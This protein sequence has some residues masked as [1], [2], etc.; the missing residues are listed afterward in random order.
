M[1]YLLI[2]LIIAYSIPGQAQ[3]RLIEGKIFAFNNYPLENIQ[4]TTK[5]S[6]ES[7][8]TDENGQFAIEVKKKDFIMIDNPLFMNYEEKIT[9]KTK[10]IN[11][12][13][14]VK[15]SDKNIK[16]A[17]EDGIIKEKELDYALK[18]LNRENNAY[19]LFSDVFEAIEYAIPESSRVEKGNGNYGFVLR[20][21]RSISGDN[22]ALTLV[23][24]S[25]IEDISCIAPAEIKSIDKL[26]NSQSALFGTRGANG[27]ISIITY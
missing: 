9:N 11:I 6:D 18:Y 2:F 23:N 20:G 17:I 10:S 15:E 4:V 24:N 25:I 19:A 12:N 8:V 16:K 14:I 13:L 1:K 21:V 27:V 3:N 5:K 7:V 26:S 22:S